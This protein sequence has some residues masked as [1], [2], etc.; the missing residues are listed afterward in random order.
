MLFSVF[1]AQTHRTFFLDIFGIGLCSRHCLFFFSLFFKFYR[2]VRQRLNLG[3][4]MGIQ[5]DDDCNG[6]L[7][8][9]NEAARYAQYYQVVTD[10]LNPNDPVGRPLVHKSAVQ[11]TTGTSCLNLT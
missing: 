8:V 9:R 3:M 1:G 6:D 10:P 4:T 11:Q 2:Y 5:D 7:S